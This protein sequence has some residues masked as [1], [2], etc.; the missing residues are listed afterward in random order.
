MILEHALLTVRRGQE[1]AFEEAMRAAAPLIGATP[2]FIR[3][4]VRPCT[5]KANIY[6]LLVE[7][8]SIEAHE[9][10]NRSAM[11]NGPSCSTDSTIRF[12][13]SCISARQSQKLSSR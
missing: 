5:E 9:V 6:L 1:A 13:R 10:E 4:A 2:G 7:W 12:P 8:E 3:L 11:A